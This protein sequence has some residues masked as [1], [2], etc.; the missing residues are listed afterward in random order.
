MKASSSGAPS[1]ARDMVLPSPSLLITAVGK[2]QVDRPSPA[3]HSRWSARI[4]RHQA[5]KIIMSPLPGINVRFQKRKSE[6][7]APGDIEG[8]KVESSCGFLSLTLSLAASPCAG[9]TL[10]RAQG[11]G[12]AGRERRRSSPHALGPKLSEK[13]AR[14]THL[15]PVS[16]V[17]PGEV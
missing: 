9:I 7:L 5:Q 15:F 12:S 10:C 8:D 14:V 2:G 13:N 6:R 16:N 4:T 17:S 11:P 3:R 1:G